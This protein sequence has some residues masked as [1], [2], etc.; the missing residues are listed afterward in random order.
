MTPWRDRALGMP[1]PLHLLHG[2]HATP[3]E[4]AWVYMGALAFTGGFLVAFRQDTASL[5]PLRLGVLVLAA[6][7]LAGGAIANLSPGTRAYWR[8]R[9]ASLRMT[10][11]AVHGVHAAA[12]AFVFSGSG[13]A[14]LLAWGW[15]LGAGA[16][17]ILSRGAAR[18]DASAMA[19]ALA[20]VAA[21]HLAPGL[22][23]AA[24]L[25]L[26]VLII[27]LVFS[28]GAGGRASGTDS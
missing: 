9:P 4:L 17:L 8:S 14:A 21:V 15:V 22:S 6:L 5:D 16:F 13:P 20:G 2:D 27:K 3:R 19:L 1:A 18:G 26:A 10:F 11:L 28:F 7:D 23:P 12:V 24:G 25:L